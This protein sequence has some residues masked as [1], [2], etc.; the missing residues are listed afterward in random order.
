[1]WFDNICSFLRFVV[2]ESEYDPTY[3]NP[4]DWGILYTFSKQQAVAGIIFNVVRRLSEVGIKPSL[5]HSF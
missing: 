1:M 2:S 4:I 3:D 5:K